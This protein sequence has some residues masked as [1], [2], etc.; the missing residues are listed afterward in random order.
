MLRDIF[1]NRW[2][3]CAIG[4]LIIFCIACFLWYQNQIATY[5][6]E[7]KQDEILLKEMQSV[8]E[9]EHLNKSLN[10]SATQG[11]SLT[12]KKE[13]TLVKEYSLREGER[14]RKQLGETETWKQERIK[15]DAPVKDLEHERLVKLA[16]ETNDPYI[17]SEFLHSQL[18]KQ[19]GDHPA[20]HT[21]KRYQMDVANGIAIDAEREIE[22]LQAHYD[23]FGDDSFLNAIQE[24]KDAQKNGVVF[25]FR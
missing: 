23:L 6:Q 21:I 12:N 22:Y 17:Q 10:K 15:H 4:F 11:V 1:T 19:F 7:F 18:L 24:I 20:V 2:I 3:L 16:Q 14:T 25:I 5:E 8:K 13:S 9:A